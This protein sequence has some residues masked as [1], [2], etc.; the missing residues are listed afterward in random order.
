MVSIPS[1]HVSFYRIEAV[2]VLFGSTTKGLDEP[3]VLS[4][5]RFHTLDVT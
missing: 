5:K 3:I 1:N 2:D 4:M